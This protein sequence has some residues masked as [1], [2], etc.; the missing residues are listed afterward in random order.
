MSF[1]WL[2]AGLLVLGIIW[3]A[4][5]QD[6]P[7][8]QK[9]YRDNIQG[10][11]DLLRYSAP[12]EDGIVQ[13]KGGELIAAWRYWGQDTE[14]AT[15]SELEAISARLNAALKR[16]GS[17]WMVHID[18][19]REHA[20]T[21]HS[22]GTFVSPVLGMMDTERRR[23]H[24]MEGR[25]YEGSYVLTV[26]YL[27]PLQVE[28]KA[29]AML[30]E[31]S[32]DMAESKASVHDLL[33]AKF[34]AEML[35]FGNELSGIFEGV[36]RLGLR[37]VHDQRTGKDVVLDD[38]LS[39]L[40]YCVTGIKQDVVAPAPGVYIDTLIGS[41][42]F[43]GGN[44][45]RIGDQHIRVLTIEGLEI[46][47]ESFPTMLASMNALPVVYRWSTR[48]IFVETEQAKSLMNS[49]RKKWRQQVRGVRDQATNS[50]SGPVNED[51]LR[52]ETDAN[53]A[54]SDAATGVVRHGHFT[55]VVIVMADSAA[56]VDSGVV[57]LKKSIRETGY[58]VRQEDI[59]A[60][61]A[62]LGSLPG[63]GHENV[64]RPIINSLNLADIIPTTASWPGL[65][66]NPSPF[67]PKKSPALVI[68]QTTGNAPFRLNLHVGDLGHTLVLG[69]TGAGKSTLLELLEAAFPRY[70]RAK[71]FKFEKGYSSF[72]LCKAAGGDYY[73]IGGEDQSLAFAPLV[74]VDS[75]QERA[76]ATEYIETLV[77]LQGCNVLSAHRNVIR[78]ALTD[79]AA[80]PPNMRT[81]THLKAAVQDQQLRDALTPYTLDGQNAMLDAESDG[82]G[83]SRFQVFEMEHLMG[84]GDR[85]AVP[86]LLY[87]FHCVERQLDGSPVLLVLDEAWLMLSHK[88]FREKIREWLKV[89]R[90][91]NCAVVFATQ[92]ISDVGNSP[93]RD[94]IYESCQ[95]KLLLAN[96]EA[97][98]NEAVYEQYKLIGLNERQIDMIATAKKKQDYY[99]MSPLGRRM[100]RLGLGPVCLAFVGASGKDDIQKVRE[101]LKAHNNNPAWVADW[102]RHCARTKEWGHGLT[103]WAD[104]YMDLLKNNA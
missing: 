87:L 7:G 86:V 77:T 13:G 36:Q 96:P 44:K 59:N 33:I 2:A 35:D 98:S 58:V 1:F 92:S 88:L 15:N 19:F 11:A 48:F 100:F 52:M 12:I 31:H 99:Y 82:F 14:S 66:Y 24:E 38:L 21:Y 75:P 68:A 60:V 84:L 30:I 70:E 5:Q 8:M 9:E 94:V 6:R 26:T 55:S 40:H 89:L 47:G 104:Y 103:A 78:Q 28:S 93:I 57:E 17:G 65:P 51:A 34:R 16:F 62:Y 49:I 71:V 72:A 63:H 102:L 79:L 42:D 25:H 20:T 67:F 46:V 95:T 41:Q 85:F 4:W 83:H 3:Y 91:A 10:F 27:P 53:S 43:V 74:R 50:Q 56:A 76:W 81:M 18:G 69:P 23:Q 32:D 39:H 73:D 29:A 45:P 90:K 22:G 97:K 64:R 101:L 37:T 54:M 61:E 80:A